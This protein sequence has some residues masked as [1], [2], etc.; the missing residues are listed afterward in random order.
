MP[1]CP[2]WRPKPDVEFER[3][4][5]GLEP[6]L[7]L[8]FEA[9][10]TPGM[11]ASEVAE[12]AHLVETAGFD[13]LG[14]SDVV[15]WP[16]SY[17]LQALAAGATE[18]ILIGALVTNP[19][20][21]HPVVHASALATLQDISSGRA[22]FG[23]GVGAGLEQIGLNPARVVTTLRET[24][25]IVRRL[26]AGEEV[27][28]R[29]QIFDIEP[30][31]LVHSPLSPVPIA[32]GTR[33]KQVATLAGEVADIALVGA[34]HFNQDLVDTYQ[35]WLAAGVA[36]RGR[37]L[38]D[39][40]VAARVTLCVSD[41][42]ELARASVKRYAA[43]YLSLLGDA[44]PA[45]AADRRI[46]IEQALNRSSGWYF[47]HDRHDDPAIG[48]LVDDDLVNQFAIAGTPDECVAQMREIVKLGFQSISCNLAAVKRPDNTMTAGLRETLEGA[49]PIIAALRPP[50]PPTETK[51]TGDTR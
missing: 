5:Q 44:G 39:L 42:G 35:Q 7:K 2:V 11:L 16:D 33:S 9:E 34:R 28:H 1:S 51:S 12:L 15:L 20:S 26:L 31:R 23:I 41:D 38:D 32:M 49:A 6:P 13:R 29:G 25:S 3:S 47:D 46:A 43:H 18:Q 17:M 36:R 37:A 10:I 4:R 22:F 21:R 8:V 50:P 27:E 40:E 14:I 24:V 30:V 19:Y 45:V 48:G